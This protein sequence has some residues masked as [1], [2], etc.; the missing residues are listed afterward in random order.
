M[1]P[2]EA[3][4]VPVPVPE[5]HAVL[6]LTAF[7]RVYEQTT[8]VIGW[9]VEGEIDIAALEG[10]L[11]RVTRKWR[12]LSG[13]MEL[14]KT[15]KGSQWRLRI[16]L[17]EIPQTFPK[18][19]LT[20]AES[21][22]PL[23][24]YIPG[25]ADIGALNPFRLGPSA[26]ALNHLFVHPSTPR[27]YAVYESTVHPLTSWHVTR[28]PGTLSEEGRSYTCIGFSRCGIFDDVGAGLILRALMAEMSSSPWH[29][30]PLPS[31]G[32]NDNPLQRA[33]DKEMIKFHVPLPGDRE[34]VG[35]STLSIMQAWK[36]ILWH[37]KQKQSKGACPKSHYLRSA[38][39]TS[40]LDNTRKEL[41]ERDHN[42]VLVSDEDIVFAW[43]ISTLY[44]GKIDVMFKGSILK[45]KIAIHNFASFRPLFCSDSDEMTLENYPFNASIP[46]PCPIFTMEEISV[47]PVADIARILATWRS[48][49]SRTH[50]L[51]TYEALQSSARAFPFDPN[52]DET[53]CLADLSECRF[54][55]MDWRH[56][57][58]QLTLALS[59]F[60][61]TPND[62]I[63]TNSACIVGKLTDGSILLDSILADLPL[64][65][66][67]IEATTN[68]QLSPITPAVDFNL[69]FV[70]NK[71]SDVLDGHST[72]KSSLI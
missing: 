15:N 28:F 65:K 26:S 70:K 7:D 9:V 10:A 30:P 45:R 37:V 60:H 47:F 46:V 63:W 40:V 20:G 42:D 38:F 17:G 19:T 69:D 62:F 52:A 72:R 35:F 49:F 5:P 59:H 18:F 2:E 21:E 71:H 11:T 1:R 39:V 36:M 61:L 33:L 31:W 53:L 68:H 48:T 4:R 43:I 58:A 23:S 67:E 27:S 3:R 44:D 13:R 34:Y 41:Q 32:V 64:R 24:K 8:F 29:A 22:K 57:G 16:P 55:E 50:V 56:I 51:L 25:L 66:L 54:A 12:I 14:L 6:P